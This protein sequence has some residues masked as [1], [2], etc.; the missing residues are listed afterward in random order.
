M[1]AVSVVKQS[2]HGSWEAKVPCSLLLCVVALILLG[3]AAFEHLM[4]RFASLSGALRDHTCDSSHAGSVLFD[5]DLHAFFGCDGVQWSQLAYCCAPA[6]PA[7][8]Q[9]SVAASVAGEA[10]PCTADDGIP[11]HL[12]LGLVWEAPQAHGSPITAYSVHARH[13]GSESGPSWELWRGSSTSCCINRSDGGGF[14]VGAGSVEVAER[15]ELTLVAHAVGGTSEPSAP[16]EL[17]PPPVPIEL[18][19]VEGTAISDGGCRRGDGG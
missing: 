6:R 19:V 3:F 1:I 17:Q 15:L 10:G 11:A 9:I 13:W 14:G 16:V 12:K 7:K 5:T 2:G 8:P 18:R 4:N